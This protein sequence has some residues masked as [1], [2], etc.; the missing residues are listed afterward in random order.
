ML[1]LRSLDLLAAF[2]LDTW[3]LARFASHLGG[4]TSDGRA[5]ERAVAGLLYRPGFTRRQ[6]P[7]N[8]SLFGSR[9]ASG[10]HHEI[11]SAADSYNGLFVVES[12]DTAGGISKADAALFHY[13]V[14]DYYQSKVVT[15]S[16]ESWWGF[17]C[18][19]SQTS[20]QVRATALSLGLL[21]CDPDR[22]PLPVLFRAASRPAA[23]MLLPETLLQEI[24][25]LGE[26]ALSTLQQRW[27]YDAR[28]RE[29][30][31]S[32]RRWR[33]NEIDDLMWLEDE[34]SAYLIALYEKN[35]PRVL[36]RRAM[37]LIRQARKV[38]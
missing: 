11:D 9:S 37:N 25:R 24:V 27:R 28:S 35:R 20:A 16:R 4:A 29:I 3:L 36:E 33:E 8:L 19:T 30:S 23:E 21:V 12:K 22:L 14:A 7:G 26:G 38:A 32:T 1:S 10:V 15:A 6:G 13:K 2:T 5:W 18:A 31:F 17:L 34:L